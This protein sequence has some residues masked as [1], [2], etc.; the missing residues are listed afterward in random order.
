[1]L[2]LYA[3]SADTD[4]FADLLSAGILVGVTT[5]PTIL[6]AAGRTLDDSP[7]L[8]ESWR[9][10]GA[11]EVFFQAV[12]SS[13]RDYV[14]SAERICAIDPAV[15]VKIPATE[16]GFAATA[17]LTRQGAPVLVT[18][19]YTPAQA[20]VA[21]AV[22]A[23]GIAPYLGRLEDLG[24]DGIATIRAMIEAIAG[25]DTAVLAASVR[26]PRS[27]AALAQLGV[28]RVT[29]RPAV[30]RQC[31]YSPDTRTAVADFDAATAAGRSQL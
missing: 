15:T 21:S 27:F 12:G 16:A 8:F 23:K 28:R 26:T 2:S 18:A 4:Q 9:Q 20:A 11:Q 24:R 25:S 19:V 5:N 29:A 22:G 3:D 17:R 13:V 6:Q 14:D 7:E 1:M 30:L 10:L 31:F